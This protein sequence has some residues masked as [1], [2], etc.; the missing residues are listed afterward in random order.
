MNP[1]SLYPPPMWLTP[2]IPA[3][4]FNALSYEEMLRQFVYKLNEVIKYCNDV[5]KFSEEVRALLEE[6]NKHVNEKVVEILTQ[7]YEDGTLQEI[8][9][10]VSAE[11]FQYYEQQ[12]ATFKLELKE[13][14]FLKYNPNDESITLSLF[15]R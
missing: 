5:Q 3:S 6:F 8:L 7:W 4:Q 10:N 12:L 1:L 15:V 11:Y 2:Q 13:N 9:Q 14:S